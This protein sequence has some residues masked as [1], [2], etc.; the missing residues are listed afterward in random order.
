MLAV[1]SRHEQV[2]VVLPTGG[3]KSL[4][5]MLPCVLPDAGVTILVLPLVSLRGDLLRRV[6]KLGIGHHVWSADEPERGSTASLVFVTVEAAATTKFRSFASTLAAKQALD[7]IVIDEAHLTI[8][9]SSYRQ[10][11]VDLA[12][13]RTVRTQFVYLTATLPPSMQA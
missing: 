4:L 13:I 2:V 10:A 7:R 5:F 12:L 1:T 6:R 9:A 11:M 8:T 3:G